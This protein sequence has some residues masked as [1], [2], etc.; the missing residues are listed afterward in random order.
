MNISNKNIFRGSIVIAFI[1]LCSPFLIKWIS[2]LEI[3]DYE[4]LS[5]LGDWIGGTSAPLLNLAGFVMILAA[6]RAQQEDLDLTR[7]E[8]KRTREAVEE[9]NQTLASQR[10]ENTFFNLISSHSRIVNDIYFEPNNMIKSR[11]RNYFELAYDE[12]YDRYRQEREKRNCGFSSAYESALGLVIDEK[13][14]E[15]AR[16][17]KEEF[18]L[19]KDCY[20]R[21]MDKHQVYIGHYLK[22]FY[23]ILRLINDAKIPRDEKN[24]YSKIL[25]SQLSKYEFLLVF[26]HCLIG[27][28]KENMGYLFMEYKYYLNIFEINLPNSYHMK[29]FHSLYKDA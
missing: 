9:Q 7:E 5:K 20:E 4:N 29:M 26:Y 12:F 25:E 1:G 21:F 22:N 23:Q 10:F 17:T 6:Y 19:L 13:E 24:N 16:K 8:M 18:I 3:T 11:G 2:G 15:I 14:E 27:E 28:E